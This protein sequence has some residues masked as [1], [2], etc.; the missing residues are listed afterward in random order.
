M[1]VIFIGDDVAIGSDGVW[2]LEHW[3]LP[4]GRHKSCHHYE[5]VYFYPVA[6]RSHWP[7]LN[8]LSVL[9]NIN[10]VMHCIFH[11]IWISISPK[12]GNKTQCK[13]VETNDSFSFFFPLQIMSCYFDEISFSLQPLI[14]LVFYSKNNKWK[15]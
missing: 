9:L 1:W 13:T 6:A 10:Q 7:A 3:P 4:V 11:Y 14:D 15:F 5:H 8:I 12:L 2:V